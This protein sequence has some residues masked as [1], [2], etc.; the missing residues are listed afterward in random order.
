MQLFTISIKKLIFTSI[1]L[2]GTFLIS[3][4]QTFEYKDSGTD[5][6]LFDLSIPEDQ[7]EIAYA[8]GSKFTFDTE[9][10]IL[11]TEDAGET[12]QTIYPLSGTSPSFE[13]I[14]FVTTE[15]GFVAGYNLFMKTEDGGTTW[16]PMSVGTGVY[17]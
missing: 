6:I 4:A 15:K 13:K 1:A 9:G 2:L 5:F 16:T 12:W 17:L 11:K 8:A 7:N 10:I 14:Q 3:Q